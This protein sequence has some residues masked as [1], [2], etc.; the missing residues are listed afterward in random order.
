M[1]TEPAGP[2]RLITCERSGRWAAALRRELAGGAVRVYETRSLAECWE[3]LAEPP[4]AFVVVELTAA[5]VEELLRRMVRLGRDFPR[6]RVAV[7]ADR[8]LAGY[9][10]LLRSSGAVHFTCSPRQFGPMAQLAC[11]HLAQVPPP[12]QSF[13]ER[14]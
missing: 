10:W 1:T 14:I 4:A 6:A 2:A 9:E 7:V 11:R 12:Q 3:A 13:T 8:P 5:G